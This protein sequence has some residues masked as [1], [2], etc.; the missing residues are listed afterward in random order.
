MQRTPRERRFRRMKAA[1]AVCVVLAAAFFA[2]WLYLATQWAPARGPRGEWL[3]LVP[4]GVCAG[5]AIV[6]RTWAGHPFRDTWR[7]PVALTSWARRR[8]LLIILG[9]A[10]FLY[11]GEVYVLR[12]LHV[13][14]PVQRLLLRAARP[15]I[16][17]GVACALALLFRTL[18]RKALFAYLRRRVERRLENERGDDH[19]SNPSAKAG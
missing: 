6:L 2:A 18:A 17:V 8:R 19:H 4:A 1:S 13:D 16:V 7:R 10:V 11:A 9:I 12:R 3:L 15:F 5:L 14:E